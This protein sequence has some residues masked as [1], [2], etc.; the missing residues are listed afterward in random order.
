MILT[1]EQATQLSK[2]IHD[3][4][5]VALYDLAEYLTDSVIF[6]DVEITLTVL[7]DEIEELRALTSSLHDLRF[8][9]SEIEA[10]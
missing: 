3:N 7:D 8:I 9:A 5:V 1:Q 2:A 10:L 4:H 6:E